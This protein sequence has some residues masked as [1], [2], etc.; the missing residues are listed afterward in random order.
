MWVINRHVGQ[1]IVCHSNECNDN[2]SWVALDVWSRAYIMSIHQYAYSYSTFMCVQYEMCETFVAKLA[3]FLFNYLL[4]LLNSVRSSSFLLSCP[5]ARVRLLHRTSSLVWRRL[6]GA[7]SREYSTASGLCSA[8]SS[9]FISF[10]F[11]APLVKPSSLIRPPSSLRDLVSPSSSRAKSLGA[12]E[13]TRETG[14][15]KQ[16][17]ITNTM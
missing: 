8:A 4:V 14:A 7:S 5:C 10:T 3:G 17:F 1:G 9:L 16:C 12:Q 13:S 2:T 11:R 6:S 15:P